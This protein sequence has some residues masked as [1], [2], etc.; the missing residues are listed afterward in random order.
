MPREKPLSAVDGK[1]G[2]LTGIFHRLIVAFIFLSVSLCVFADEFDFDISAGPADAALNKYARITGVRLL[3][4]F[5]DVSKHRTNKVVG[6]FEGGI[7]LRLLLQNTGLSASY[8]DRGNLVI[9]SDVSIDEDAQT[10]QG[11]NMNK[12]QSLLARMGA[13][14]AGLFLST[15]A[16]GQ[17]AGEGQSPNARVIEEVIVTAQKREQNVQDL[18]MSVSAYSGETMERLAI[19]NSQE[20]TRHTINLTNRAALGEGSRP[21]YYMRGVG[22]ADFNSNNTG[23]VGVYVD[24][25]YMSSLASQM[26]PMFDMDRVEILRGPQGTLFG[27]NTSAGAIS[28]HTRAPTEE[29]EGYVKASAGNFGYTRVDAAI[30]GSLS[31]TVAGRL[32]VVKIDS[33]GYMDNKAGSVQ[34]GARDILA[35]RGRLAWDINEDVDVSLTLKSSQDDSDSAGYR[36]LGLADPN[37]FAPCAPAAIAAGQ[38]VDWLGYRNTNSDFYSGEWDFGPSNDTETVGAVVRL[39]WQFGDVTFTSLTGWDDVDQTLYEDADASPLDQASVTY[40]VEVES[41]SQEFRLVGSSDDLH[42]VVGAYFLS[43]ELKQDQTADVY[44]E[45]RPFFGF[46]PANFVLFSRHTTEQNTDSYAVFGQ[47]EYDF[48]DKLTATIGLRW[49]RE[50]R[51]FEYTSAIEEPDFAIPLFTQVGDIE[52]TDVS[53]RFVLDYQ[54][55]N[56]VL[57][58]FSIAEGFKAGGFNG[59]FLFDPT[60]EIS[61]D[62]ENLLAYEVGMKGDFLDNTLRLN[63]SLFYYDYTDMQVFTFINDRNNANL[64]TQVLTNASDA[65]VLGAELELEWWLT[66]RLNMRF[67]LGLLDTELKDF[68]SATGEDFSGN[69]LPLAADFSATA[70]ANYTIPLGNGGTLDLQVDFSYEDGIYFTND[71]NPLLSQDGYELWNARVTYMSPEARWELSAYGKNLNREEYY[72]AMFDFSDFAL[73]ELMPGPDTTYGVEFRVNF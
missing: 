46:D 13:A 67:G 18:A 22:L 31:D 28:F 51:D 52:D 58:Y 34:E 72:V 40:G 35:W 23:P 63:A 17:G 6:R 43:E 29:F 55:N 45:L 44:R 10:K 38:C 14:V 36:H 50:D 21:A 54:L 12:E 11:D 42:W 53:P 66:D 33:D 49:T 61:Y 57:L 2:Y 16:V 48:S 73:Y 5:D 24:E 30:G 15:T 8:S 39:N 26:V 25:V 19:N 4:R 41:F 37:T 69:D 59:G 70:I 32:A 20:L 68:E 56:D 71:N 47:V 65:E 7:A 60:P 1:E 64:P 9:T 27:R 62:S 3:F